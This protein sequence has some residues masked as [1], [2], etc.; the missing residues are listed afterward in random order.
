[1][2]RRHRDDARRARRRAISLAPCETAAESRESFPDGLRAIPAGGA[3]FAVTAFDPPGVERTRD[4][5]RA[6]T[7][8]SGPC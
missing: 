7:A 8:S 3:A 2:G 6:R 4:E 1:M 5:K